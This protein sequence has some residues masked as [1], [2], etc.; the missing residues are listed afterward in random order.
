MGNNK[1]IDGLQ[2]KSRSNI[3]HIPVS[4]RSTQ[5]STSARRNI[6]I[7]DSKREL[8]KLARTNEE[9][10]SARESEVSEDDRTETAEGKAIKEYL[11]EIQDVDPTD[12]TEVPQ[13]KKTKGWGKKKHQKHPKLKKPKNKKKIIKRII[14]GIVL[15]LVIGLAAAYFIAND[16][17]SKITDNGNVLNVIFS[18]PDTPLQKDENGRTNV[19]IFGTEGYDMND[20]K[21]DGGYLTDSMMVVSFD[22]DS[23]DVKAVSLPR[24][25]K[26]NT[27]TSTGKMNEL[28][29]CKYNK[30][31][32]TTEENKKYEEEG[33]ASLQAAFEEVLG[34]KIQY[35]V[36]LNWQ[37]LIKVVDS[38]G[39]IDVVFTYGDQTWDGDETT[40]K[41]TDKRGLAD[42]PKGHYYLQYS[43]GKVY[44]L[45]GAAAL[46]VA[47]AR[48][49]ASGS[50][51]ASG[52]NFSREYFQQ[53]I[54]EAIAKK[55]KSSNITSDFTKVMEIKS[56]IGDN[57]R[58]NFKDTELKT[59]VKL[60]GEIDMPSMQTIS[61]LKPDD[62]TS[63][64]LTTGMINKISYVLPSAGVGN[65][66][67][68]HKYI[69]KKLSN[70]Y[71]AEAAN[72]E[73]LNGTSAYG[74]ASTEK[75]SLEDAG[76]TVSGTANAPSD[77][78]GFDGVRVYEINHKAKTAEALK[79]RY[80][81]DL[82]TEIPESLKSYKC[83][84][85]VIV[86]NGYSSSSQS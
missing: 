24:D 77:Q 6:G 21:Y 47:R 68:I 79:K 11:S 10:L 4:H 39:G 7:P 33:A 25:L 48:N 22:Q 73:V 63:P 3:N 76:F 45:D 30:S 38:I 20:P 62:G 2:R 43:T 69:Q 65:Y 35:H 19:L 61:L 59:L 37:A 44:H 60:A 53:R 75:T 28:Y 18:D 58:S 40:I 85:I 42:G 57:L 83:D 64:L 15:L 29:W 34:I 8:R 32:G 70:S 55:A 31:N 12:L 78:S 9:Q 17:V 23:G 66:T 56:A 80:N 72:I 14:I 54:I 41:V 86:G 46:G 74:I 49:E 13:K 51:G 27:C 71:Q 82:T 50:Y 5:K 16:F 1:T 36:H 84:Y 81:V 26:T 67:A 52:G